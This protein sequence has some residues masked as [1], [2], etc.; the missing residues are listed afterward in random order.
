MH[1]LFHSLTINGK[2]SRICQAERV[3]HVLYNVP[4]NQPTTPS[5]SAREAFDLATLNLILIRLEI[6]NL[7]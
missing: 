1:I 6:L 7:L 4:K 2:I 5:R 3:P